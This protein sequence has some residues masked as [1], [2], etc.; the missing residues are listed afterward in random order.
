MTP[1]TILDNRFKIIKSIGEGGMA[2]VYL[3]LDTQTNQQVAIKFMRLDLRDNPDFSRRFAREAESASKLIHPNITQ[4]YGTGTYD[5]GSQYLVMEYVDGT[6]LKHYIKD[7]FPIPYQKVV[8]IVSQILAGLDAAHSAG[9]VHRDIKPQNILIDKAGR[10]KIVDFGISLARSEFGMTQTNTVLGSVHYLS[11][12][13]TRG[14]ITTNKSDI[15]A[16]GI[17]L[18]E[19]L[20]GK[21]PFEGETAV[22]VALKHSQT[23]IPLVR[24]FDKH[25]PQALENVIIK[26]TAKN[27]NNRY[28]TAEDMREDLQTALSSRRANEEKLPPFDDDLVETRVIPVDEIKNQV[29]SG[30]NLEAGKNAENISGVSNSKSRWRLLPWLI[31]GLITVALGVIVAAIYAPGQVSVP[32]TSGLTEAA[33]RQL[34]EENDLKVGKI[35][36]GSSEKVREDL[37]A[38]TKP[39]AGTRVD[40]KMTVDIVISTGK[41]KIRMDNFVGSSYNSA[42]NDLKKSGFKVNKVTET[43]DVPEGQVISQS[44]PEGEMVVA[45]ETTVELVVSGGKQKISVP[46]FVGQTVSQAIAWGQEN[47]IEIFGYGDDLSA[48]ITSQSPSAGSTIEE[49]STISIIVKNDQA[50]SSSSQA[51]DPE[52]SSS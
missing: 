51:P 1:D 48:T 31:G 46:D 15:Y 20:T 8:D 6:D 38:G 37:V 14:G 47:N 22:S 30:I 45:S 16:T 33:A 18:Y 42:A 21:V 41:K 17:I 28:P 13:Q 10:V 12:E 5:G 11:P 26:A 24:D 50:S 49:G 27:P 36:E 25:I 7:N 35:T 23:S 39:P 4:V 3:A 40:K 52:D 9:I 2:N 43:S 34:L 44:I 19:L 29:Q 32:D